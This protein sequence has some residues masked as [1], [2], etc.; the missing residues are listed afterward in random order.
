[1]SKKI[2]FHT[3]K[4]KVPEDMISVGKDGTLTIKKTL[5]KSKVLSKVKGEPSINIVEDKNII[6][7]MIENKGDIIDVDEAKEKKKATK[8]T[9]KIMN[10]ILTT[11]PENDITPKIAR[12]QKVKQDILPVF[13]DLQ[14]KPHKWESI[15]KYEDEKGPQE[16]NFDIPKKRRGRKPK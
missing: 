8:K 11:I 13:D 14:P 3:I 10:N 16:Y 4:I 1:M 2:L 12:K 6:T 9:K 7:P 5:T 15:L